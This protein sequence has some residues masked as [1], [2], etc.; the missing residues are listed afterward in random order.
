MK[1]RVALQRGVTF[2]VVPFGLYWWKF[3]LARPM[4]APWEGILVSLGLVLVLVGF[5]TRIVA[6]GYK[7]SGSLSG[8][9]LVT[10]DLYAYVRNPMYMGTFLIGLGAALAV[11]HPVAV[12]IFIVGYAAI[13][14]PQ[15]LREER[16]LT[17]HFGQEYRDYCQRT[18]RLIPGPLSWWGFF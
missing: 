8:G 9:R 5:C 10:G 2:L 6:R 11:F 7:E 4:G 1:K 15:I 17:G 13:Y 3:L 18:P 12:V 14:V 16:I